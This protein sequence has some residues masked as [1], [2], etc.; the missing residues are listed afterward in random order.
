MQKFLAHFSTDKNFKQMKLSYN[1]LKQYVDFDLEPEKLSLVLTDIGLEVE[2]LEKFQSVK[3]GLEGIVIGEVKTC[4]RHSNADKLSVTTVDVGQGDLLPIVCG[5]PNVEAGQKVLVATV[6]TK[7][8]SGEDS[9]EIKKAKIRGEVSE[10]MICAEDELGLGESHD[11]IMVLPAETKVGLPAK[12]YFNIEEDYIFEI[13]LTPNRADAA[14]HIGAAIDLVAGLNRLQNTRKYSLLVPSVVSFKVDDNSLDIGVEVEDAEACPRYTGITLSGIVVGESPEWLKNR[15]NGIGV[16][17]IN[18]IVDIT[19]YVLHETGQPLHA[20]DADEIKGNKV[21]IRK[22]PQNTP[23]VTLDEIER[24]L[25]KND[26]MICDAEDGMCIA[27]VFGGVHSGVT[28]KTTSIFLESAYFDPSHIRKTSKRHALQTDASFRFERGTDPN[29]TEYALKRAIMLMQEVAGGKVSSEIKDVYPKPIEKWAVE[30]NYDRVNRLIGNEIPNEVIKSILV[31]LNIEIEEETNEGLKLMIPTNKVDVTREADVIEEILRV[32]GF[33]N[34]TFVDK[35]SASVSVRP[36]PDLEKIQNMISDQL[37]SKGFSEIMNNS[38][39]N[40]D[41]YSG[42]EAFE[43]QKNVKLLNALSQDLDILRQSLLFGGLEVIAYNNNRKTS[44]L[45]L[46]EFGNTYLKK[47]DAS[48]LKKYTEQKHLSIFACGLTDAENWNSTNDR[49]DFYYLKGILES[50]MWRLGLNRNNLEI[51]ELTSS[52]YKYALSYAVNGKQLGVVA[53]L[54]KKLL[55]VFDIKE[56]VFMADVNWDVVVK[57]LSRKDMQYNAVPKFP[58]VRRDLALLIDANIKFA[59]LKATA[60]NAER[61]LLKSVGIFDVYEGD[62]IPEGKKSY[63]LSFT[64]QDEEKTLTDKIIEKTM[65]R[66]QQSLEQE[67]KAELR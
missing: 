48:G 31:D 27:G 17:P 20:F 2:G 39:T 63:A 26:L 67:F 47:G 56:A 6:G 30:I 12:E 44:D 60:L 24:K 15:L 22:S 45:K 36:K 16:R 58:A 62:K 8:Y 23:F 7:L 19:N 40:S 55:S 33:N 46:Y 28:E 4:E 42:N 59:D 38:I 10:G 65:R 43:E 34:I 1:W 3:G 9:F 37:S 66:I 61:R 5:A 18:N 21:V 35:L 14:S 41:Y 57:N 13:G 53:E 49:V 25:D 32:Y 29:I 51:S 52:N 11:G 50:V 64:L 54:S